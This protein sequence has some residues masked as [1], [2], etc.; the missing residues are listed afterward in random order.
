MALRANLKTTIITIILI[1]IMTVPNISFANFNFISTSSAEEPRPLGPTIYHSFDEMETELFQIASDHPTITK[2]ES[3]GKTYE[4]RE[5]WAMKVSDNPDIEEDEPEIFY[6]AMHH[7]REW[8]T[9]EVALYILNYLT[10]NYLSNST[11][12]DIVDSR[13]IWIIS[14]VNPDGRV[15][16]SAGDDPTSHRSQTAGWRKNRADHGEGSI[17]VDLNRN[18]GYMWGGAGASRNPGSETYRGPEPF[19]ELETQAIRDFVSQHDFVFAISYHAHGQMILYP[20]GYTY[21]DPAEEEI[22]VKIGENMDGLITNNAGSV[23]SS[24]A[25]KQ[26]SDLYLTSGTDNDWLYGQMGIYAYTIELYP[27]GDDDDAAIKIPYDRFHPRE[28]KVIPVCQD[29]IEAALYIAQIADNPNQVFDYHVSLST[30][31]SSQLINQTETDTFP[32]TI[33]NDGATEDLY[34]IETST[35]SGWTININPT[36]IFV[37]SES[38]SE[39]TLTVTVPPGTLGGQ[40]PIW[41]NATSFTNSSIT[42]SLKVIVQVPYYNDV[43]I[44]SQ[45]TFNQNDIYPMRDYSILSTT[46]NYGRNTQSAYDVSLEIV[47]LG[48]RIT[49]TVFS[50]DM[51][52]GIN[53]WEVED[54]D[55]PISSGFWKQVT[56]SS[57]S[58]TTSW[59][60]G[61]STQ[62]TNLCVQT[63]TSPPFSLKWA[64]SAN[65]LFYHKY[66]TENNYDFASVDIWEGEKWNIIE[67]YDGTGPS[68][69]EQVSIS[70]DDYLGL[71]DL[72]IRFRFASDNFV[73]DDG[74]YI[75]DVE[76]SAE[77]PSETTVYGPVINS[78]SVVLG[79]DAVQQLGWEFTF[80]ETGEYKVYVTTLLGSDE[81][82]INN[83]SAVKI[84]VTPPDWDNIPLEYGWN[85][86]SL[87][88]LQEDVNLELVLESIEGDYDAIQFY[89]IS[90]PQDLW[91][92]HQITKPANL[93]DLYFIDH[94]MGFWIHI[95]EPG[96]T[97]LNTTGWQFGSPESVPLHIGWNLV[98]Y[99]SLTSYNRTDGLNG[100]NFGSEVNVI[101]WYDAALKTWHFMGPSDSFVPGRGYW[102]HSKVETTWD[103]PL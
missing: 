86:I 88:L 73:V 33:I 12:T 58:P 78:T 80:T 81:Y 41:V 23:N 65:L 43:G 84:E 70:I 92:H 48:P 27:H 96:G 53:G 66:K 56:S 69:F 57:N 15:W 55:G 95:I 47:K 45:D 102:I 34:N 5:I 99:P 85:L 98:G 39:L 21:N 38:S 22:F 49:Q 76:I 9:M 10:D 75:D 3:I 71:E 36:A 14:C 11:I 28:D 4:G 63:L 90:E 94:T 19:S 89:N 103:V 30:N 18:Y 32:I 54:L 61:G 26:G 7:A 35:I 82:P 91:K 50:D 52:S 20:Y 24:Y 87:P 13:Q 51:E 68:S 93:N 42:A 17:G 77:F 79:Q 100:L 67:S 44:L 62:Y 1:C 83:Q 25:V 101:Q 16:D 72:R 8:L 59:W 2:L 29:N 37:L 6:N 74:W 64:E 40:Y 46:K 60:C 97:I 31:L